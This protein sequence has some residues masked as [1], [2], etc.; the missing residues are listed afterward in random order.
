MVD[1]QSTGD[2]LIGRAFGTFAEEGFDYAPQDCWLIR[3]GARFNGLGSF[4]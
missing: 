2:G 1:S 4:L 3:V